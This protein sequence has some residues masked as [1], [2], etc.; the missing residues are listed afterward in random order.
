MNTNEYIYPPEGR[1]G[2]VKNICLTVIPAFLVFFCGLLMMLCA[3]F[4]EGRNRADIAVQVTDSSKEETT[5]D[6]ESLQTALMGDAEYY[7]I[8]EDEDG[9]ISVYLSDGK[10]YRQ[11]DILAYT[12]PMSDRAKLEIGIMVKSDSELDSYIDGFSG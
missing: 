11:L 10:L 8:K 6:A 4:I 9:Y 3:L 2:Q 7:V 5:T 12:L 1:R